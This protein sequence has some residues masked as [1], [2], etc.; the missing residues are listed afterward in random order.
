MQTSQSTTPYGRR[1]YTLALMESQIA[2]QSAPAEA[3]A[4][5]WSVLNDL[6]QANGALG[7]SE[8][9]LTVLNAL[10]SFHQE[11]TLTGGQPIIVFPSNKN[12]AQRANCMAENTLRRHL[13]ALVGLGL[14]LRRDSPNGKRYARIGEGGEIDEAFGFDLSPL[15][16][17]AEEFKRLAIE[18]RA[19]ERLLR[20]L[21]DRITTSRR[22]IDKMIA[23]GLYE[24]IPADWTAFSKA[25]APLN[26]RLPRKAIFE[27]LEPLVTA[28]EDLADRIRK[29]LE[30]YVQNTNL[31]GNDNHA[32]RHIHN[33]TQNSIFESETSQP[34][35]NEATA[36]ANQ[37]PATP[38]QLEPTPK[39]Q[40]RSFPLPMVLDACPDIAEHAPYGIGS[41]RDLV[42][43]AALVAPWLGISPSAWEDAKEAL[44]PEDAAVVLAAILQRS[45]VINS[46]GGYLRKLTEKA[47]AGTFSIGPVL[48]ALINAKLRNNSQK[49][50][51]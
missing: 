29:T 14:I 2:A 35:S 3:F 41:W 44:G 22:D 38:L 28:L 40:K 16:A 17:R 24:G 19:A 6:R 46:A 25:F 12:L 50:R 30:S 42:S 15:V 32:E 27:F 43:T 34:I 18:T 39:P 10:I 37:V 11:T 48:M 1:P 4:N 21:R 36:E 49:Q 9:A 31:S 20:S 13:A 45:T 5:K 26:G 7:V 47:R 33:S 51:A 23:L 8:R